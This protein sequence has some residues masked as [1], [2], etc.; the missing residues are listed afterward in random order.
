MKFR[1]WN[2]R[3]WLVFGVIFVAVAAVAWL[4]YAGW[5]LPKYGP[6][7]HQAVGIF[8]SMSGS[9][10]VISGFHLKDD[11]PATPVYSLRRDLTVIIDSNTKLVRSVWHIPYSR[12]YLTKNK[13]TLDAGTVKIE[14]QAGSID[15]LKNISG[16]SITVKTADNSIRKNT[17]KATEISYV[18]YSYAK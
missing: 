13:T 17:L 15:D 12:E 1:L 10:L 2:S 7:S 16:M 6:Q 11:S 18:L 14:Q 4:G 3:Q 9:Q 8:K 5:Y